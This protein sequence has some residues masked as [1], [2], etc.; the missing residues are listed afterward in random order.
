ML[1]ENIKTKSYFKNLDSMAGGDVLENM[2]GGMVPC[3]LPLWVT[4]RL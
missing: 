3:N 4:P 1:L 2:A